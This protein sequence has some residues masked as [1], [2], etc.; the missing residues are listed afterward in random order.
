M[1]AAGAA[2]GATPSDALI[3]FDTRAVSGSG[4]VSS[5]TSAECT[6]PMDGRCAGSRR[7]QAVMSVRMTGGHFSPICQVQRRHE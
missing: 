5:A 4:V 3:S 2:A 1:L 7:V 6:A